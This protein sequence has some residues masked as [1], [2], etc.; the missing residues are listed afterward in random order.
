MIVFVLTIPRLI[1]AARYGLIG[2][3]TYYAIWSFYPGFGYYDHSPAVAWVIWLG[4]AIFGEGEWAVRSLFVL[5]TFAICAALYR[6]ATLLFEDR[7]VGAVAAIAYAVTPARRDHL[8]ARDPGRTVDA[9]L[10]A[11]RVGHRRVHA[12]PRSPTGGWP[13]DCSQDWACCRSTP[14]S[15]LASASC[16]I[17][18]RAASGV[19]WLRLWQVWAGGV[20]ALALFAPV[21]WID[22]TRDWRRSA[23]SSDARPL[24]ERVLR[25]DELLRFLI[26]IGIQLLPTL[27]V[28][29]LI[30]IV[31]FFAR[32]ASRWRCRC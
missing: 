6:I 18:S 7:R 11:D 14:W 25:P 3:E 31:L 12:E 4:R 28:F 20:I 30:G 21:V 27:L 10:G 22:W 19:A 32:R 8:H 1:F 17:S 9:V 15:S 13:R 5:S 2:D 24:A 16:S 29:A 23:S 26:E